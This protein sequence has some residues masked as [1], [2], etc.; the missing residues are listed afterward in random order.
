[1]SQPW[2]P[3]PMGAH[4]CGQSGWVERDQLGCE[5]R[6]TLVVAIGPAIFDRDILVWDVTV[7]LEA[8]QEPVEMGRR[9][10]P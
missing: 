5:H 9:F 8:P 2:Q 3:A 6:Q 10:F 4:R 7:I 1:M